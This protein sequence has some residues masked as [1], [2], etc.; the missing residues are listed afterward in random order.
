MSFVL[1]GNPLPPDLYDAKG[2]VI[3]DISKITPKRRYIVGC[4]DEFL[5]R[6]WYE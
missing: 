2:T 3:T 1:F 4:T 6:Q 5:P